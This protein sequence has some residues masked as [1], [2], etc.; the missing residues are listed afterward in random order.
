M[1]ATATIARPVNL[2]VKLAA[3]DRERLEVLAVSKKRTAHH[4]MKEAI[5]RYLQEE[6]SEERF[7]NAAEASA[8][9]FEKTGL[10]ITLDEA[11]TW[12]KALKTKPKATLARC[13]K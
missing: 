8:D 6:E 13:H 12:A 9:D 4:I 2:T 1:T 11:K 3:A 7:V 10:H 5:Q